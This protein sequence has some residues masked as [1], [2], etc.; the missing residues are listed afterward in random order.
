MG[1]RNKKTCGRCEFYAGE[2]QLG[3]VDCGL[4][5]GQ[6]VVSAK[7]TG[8]SCAFRKWYADLDVVN[9][10]EKLVREALRHRVAEAYLNPQ[11]LALHQSLTGVK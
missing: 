3:T 6:V 7:C 8:V 2:P 5:K 11:V 9:R 4:I 10:G 1:T